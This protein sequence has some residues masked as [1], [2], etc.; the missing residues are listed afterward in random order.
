MSNVDWGAE[1]Y[2]ELA[3]TEQNRYFKQPTK[4]T[5]RNEYEIRTESS[6]SFDQAFWRAFNDFP[7]EIIAVRR[8]S[9]NKVALKWRVKAD[10]AL[11]LADH[12]WRSTIVNG[13]WSEKL[14]PF[15]LKCGLF[16]CGKGLL[17][18]PI[19]PGHVLPTGQYDPSQA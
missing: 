1:L 14:Y 11:P 9:E 12:H 5:F 6:F 17:D 4:S 2:G 19:Q 7:F 10:A 3:K 8:C 18:H 16:G 13:G 15:T